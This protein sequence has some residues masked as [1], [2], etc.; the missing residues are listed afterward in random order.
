MS[1][2]SSEKN[3][4]DIERYYIQRISALEDACSMQP[5][6]CFAFLCLKNRTP[7]SVSWLRLTEMAELGR[8]EGCNIHRYS[9]PI[10]LGPRNQRICVNFLNRIELFIWFDNWGL[11]LHISKPQPR[12]TPL[13]TCLPVER[14]PSYCWRLESLSSNLLLIK[15]LSKTPLFFTSLQ[16]F[17]CEAML[18]V[19]RRSVQ[20]ICGWQQPLPSASARK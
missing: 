17:R 13:C 6:V 9:S 11:E 14:M 2:F 18:V 3:Q 8:R 5:N 19:L 20:E 15:S 16:N 1:L 4:E 7:R 12:M 10:C